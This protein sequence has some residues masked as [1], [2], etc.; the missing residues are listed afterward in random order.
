MDLRKEIDERRAKRVNNLLKRRGISTDLAIVSRYVEFAG[1][2][3]DYLGDLS[4]MEDFK[5]FTRA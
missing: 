5:E 2:S 3:L 1:E 4:L